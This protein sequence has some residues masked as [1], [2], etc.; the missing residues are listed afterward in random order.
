MQR[1]NG[2]K[3]NGRKAHVQHQR[4]M[5]AFLMRWG[6]PAPRFWETYGETALPMDTKIKEKHFP[7]SSLLY[8][9]ECLCTERIYNCLY[10][11]HTDGHCGLL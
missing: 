8:T 10:D 1:F 4:R 5:V 2:H 7:P 3:R 11:H 6:L 9:G